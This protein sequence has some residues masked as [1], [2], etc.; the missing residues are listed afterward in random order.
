MYAL[1]IVLNETEYT[2]RILKR[3]RELGIKSATVIESVGAAE[4]VEN[5]MYTDSVFASIINALETRKKPS[6][7]IFSILK[8]E[9]LVTEAMDEVQKILG[10]DMGEKNKGI[11]FVLPVTH[12]CGEE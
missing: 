11:V 12:M 7:I 2:S 1:F 10:E 3:I 8:T 9:E 5:D 6:C 4:V